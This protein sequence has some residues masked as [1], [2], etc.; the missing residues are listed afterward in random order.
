VS[1]RRSRPGDPE[2]DKAWALSEPQFCGARFFRVRNLRTFT[3]LRQ[4]WAKDNFVRGWARYRDQVLMEP[5]DDVPQV[6]NLLRELANTPYAPNSR[7]IEMAAGM[8][9][10]GIDSIEWYESIPKLTP[11]QWKKH[12]SGMIDHSMAL[13]RLLTQLGDGFWGDE[14]ESAL[15]HL[16]RLRE[17]A[18]WH[19]EDGG[20][21]RP[22]SPSGVRTF[23]ARNILEQSLR[24]L[25]NP[26]Y[27]LHAIV[28]NALFPNL[29]E[30]GAGYVQSLARLL[31]QDQ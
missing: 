30:I 7:M 18:Q 10:W 8:I 24:M 20:L 3:V 16:A 17:L 15:E 26:S 14:F 23:V 5:H 25:I 4:A 19:L 27:D 9:D 28:L 2:A 13:E 22:N 12:F 11:T 31:P 29:P 1:R 6:A 21:P